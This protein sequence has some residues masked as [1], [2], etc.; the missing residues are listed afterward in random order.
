MSII[1]TLFSLRGKVAVVTG[2][3]SGIGHAVARALGLA[4]AKLILVA[5]REKALEEATERLNAEGGEA[6][7]IACDLADR[8]QITACAARARTLFGIPDIL[9]NA[10]GINLRRPIDDVSWSDWDTTLAINL[11]APFFLSKEL[12]SGM[13][14]KR[15]GRIINIASL[16]SVRAFADSAP[17]GASKGGVV[18]L[19]RAQAQAW[20]RDGIACNAIAPGF[21]P[22]ALTAPVFGDPAR[23]SAVAARTMIGRAGELAELH[24]VAVFLASPASGYITGQTIFVDGGFSA[25]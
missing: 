11:S 5:R 14:E 2:G 21:F 12:A 10:A 20:S 4:G 22:T 8:E 15:W 6:K 9:V 1:D 18:Q 23:A 24:G 7:Y 3:N 13:I 25:G 19:T 16:Q 17:Y